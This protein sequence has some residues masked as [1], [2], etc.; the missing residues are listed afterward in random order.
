[1]GF[2]IHRYGFIPYIVFL[3][4]QYTINAFKLFFA[5]GIHMYPIFI[6]IAV[7]C[8]IQITKVIIDIIRYKRLYTGHI[9]ASG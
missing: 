5:Q 2:S 3:M 9:F 6:V 4:I 8:I 7:G 1:M